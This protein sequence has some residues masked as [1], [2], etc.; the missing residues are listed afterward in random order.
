[1]NFT[2]KSFNQLLLISL[3]GIVIFLITSWISHL[4]LRRWHETAAVAVAAW[5]AVMLPALL[6]GL[7]LALGVAL[8]I[9]KAPVPFVN[10]VPLR[11]ADQDTAEIERNRNWDPNAPLAGKPPG[12]SLP[13]QA[14]G[15]WRVNHVV[16]Q[17]MGW[18]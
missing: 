8:Y 14:G 12:S 15:P 2:R 1:M 18:Q 9:T 3:S 4:L 5:C 10:K 13:Q 6:V 7:V 16:N 11:T 17:G